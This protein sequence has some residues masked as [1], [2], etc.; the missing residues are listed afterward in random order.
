MIEHVISGKERGAY[1]SVV[2]GEGRFAYLS[3]V[4]P[5]R[6]GTLIAGSIEEQT[7][8]TLENLLAGVERIGAKKEDIVKCGCF[9]SDIGLSTRFNEEYKRFFGSTFPART[10]VGVFLRPD[11]QIEIDAVVMLS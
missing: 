9:L 1:S 11:M 4:G 3:G 2:V 7:A 6:D 5:F 8:L 10:T